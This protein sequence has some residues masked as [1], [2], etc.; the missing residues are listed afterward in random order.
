MKRENIVQLLAT[1]IA[2]LFFYAAI[3]KLLDYTQSRQQMLAQVFPRFIALQLVWAVPVAELL[4]VFGLLFNPARLKSLYA[5]LVLLT[6]FTIY[7]AAAM[8]GVFGRIPCSCGG[9]LSGLGYWDHLLFNFFFILLAVV[10][11]AFE[12]RNGSV[13]IWFHPVSRK[14]GTGIN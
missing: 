2:L 1:A 13:K 6:L 11:I 5:S 9:I 14:E 8:T 10:A 12:K 7:I 4:I 3:S